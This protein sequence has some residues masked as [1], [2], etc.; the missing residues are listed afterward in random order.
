MLSFFPRGVLGDPGPLTSESGALPTALRGPATGDE[1]R[2]MY[3]NFVCIFYLVRLRIKNR[4]LKVLNE[5]RT[6]F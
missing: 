2:K 4:S 5:V 3:W 6:L 1:K